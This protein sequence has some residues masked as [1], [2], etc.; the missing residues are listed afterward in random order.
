M[1]NDGHI[2]NK[3]LLDKE[4]EPWKTALALKTE[5]SRVQH[6]CGV[7]EGNALG[8]S[9]EEDVGVASA[10]LGVCQHG[11]YFQLLLLA[12]AA[13]LT[14]VQPSSQSSGVRGHTNT[15]LSP[16]TH[17]DNTHQPSLSLS[18]RCILLR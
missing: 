11:G 10:L 9:H 6:T 8:F 12:P 2:L 5:L 17:S 13:L 7:D 14:P 4:I 1:D 15:S 18:D 3:Y 16:V